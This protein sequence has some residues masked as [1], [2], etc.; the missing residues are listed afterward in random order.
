M[1]ILI[2]ECV[3]PRVAA[4]FDEH[5]AKTVREMGWDQLLDGPLLQLAALRLMRFARAA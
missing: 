3:D 1:R 4:L 2:D 5:D